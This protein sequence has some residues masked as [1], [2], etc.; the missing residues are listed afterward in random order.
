MLTVFIP[1][2]ARVLLHKSVLSGPSSPSHLLAARF[3]LSCQS[4]QGD[5]LYVPGIAQT[6]VADKGLVR[7]KPCLQRVY[8]P[9]IVNSHPNLVY[10]DYASVTARLITFFFLQSIYFNHLPTLL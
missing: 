6:A 2:P 9:V 7:F 5:P 10:S 4:R 3:R 8:R 1:S